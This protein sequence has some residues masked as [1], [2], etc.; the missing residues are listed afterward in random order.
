M[1]PFYWMLPESFRWLLVKRKYTKAIE[2]VESAAKI[3]GISLS[4][5]TY[6]I[7]AMKCQYE[8]STENIIVESSGTFMDIIKSFSL[9]TRLMICTFCWVSS[10]FITYGVS[11]LSVQ[12]QGDKYVSILYFLCNFF[13]FD[14]T[15]HNILIYLF[16]FFR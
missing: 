10:T 11:I 6:D 13:F 8:N 4:P 14:F 7:I 1:F 16:G 15:L 5:K 2:T 9:V 12:L 3:N